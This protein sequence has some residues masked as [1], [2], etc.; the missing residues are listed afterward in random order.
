[1][2]RVAVVGLGLIG[3]SIGLGL[4]QW[5]AQQSKE[6]KPA[7]E[8]VGFDTDLEQQHYAKKINAVDRAEWELGKAIRDAD[9][10][11]LAIPVRAIR[12]SFTDIAPMLKAGAVVTD[13]GSTKAQV[14]EWAGELL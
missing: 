14:L 3:G 9:I 6:G 12:E 4:K 5:S 7:L 10:V 2:Q 1:M 13:V 8:V 11:V